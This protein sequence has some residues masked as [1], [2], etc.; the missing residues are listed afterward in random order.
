MTT[1]DFTD[2][3]ILAPS[4]SATAAQAQPFGMTPGQNSEP[5]MPAEAVKPITPLATWPP[6][7]LRP[8]PVN[9][10]LGL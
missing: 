6:V 4:N 9:P 1:A 2:T 3:A 7:A 5:A 8:R 10:W